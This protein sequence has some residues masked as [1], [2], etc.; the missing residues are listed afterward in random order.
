MATKKMSL[1]AVN[2]ETLDLVIEHLEC[3]R[4]FA[5]KLAFAKG[6]ANT[7]GAA[8]PILDKSNGFWTIPDNIIRGDD[9][10]LFK[11]L[12]NNNQQQNIPE[13]QLD[14][15]ILLYIEQGLIIMKAEL[16]N[17]TSLEDYR[18]KVIQ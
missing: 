1:T 12:V 8:N 2:K 3:E 15:E 13:D 7:Q 17:L 5:I 6:I 16:E 10:L 9:F 4:P 18:L 14:K 11:H